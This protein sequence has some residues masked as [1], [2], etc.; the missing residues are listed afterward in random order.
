MEEEEGGAGP[1]PSTCSGSLHP[2]C[3]CVRLAGSTTVPR[4]E[5]SFPAGAWE[6]DTEMCTNL[7]PQVLAKRQGER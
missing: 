7:S 5:D 4:W 6:V 1:P 2:D 3:L